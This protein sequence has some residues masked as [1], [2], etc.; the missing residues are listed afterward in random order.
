MVTLLVVVAAVNYT[1]SFVL[2]SCLHTC[3]FARYESQL[4]TSSTYQMFFHLHEVRGRGVRGGE[5]GR[6]GLCVCVCACVRA[7]VCVCVCAFVCVESNMMK[8]SPP[9]PVPTGPEYDVE[10]KARG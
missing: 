3:Q 8:F 1:S 5:G 2:S 7:C 9:P 10:R 4:F 6:G